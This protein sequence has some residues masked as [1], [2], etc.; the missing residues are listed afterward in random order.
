MMYLKR[1]NFS[2]RIQIQK[3]KVQ[4]CNEKLEKIRIFLVAPFHIRFTQS[5]YVVKLKRLRGSAKNHSKFLKI[6]LSDFFG[7]Q[8]WNLLWLTLIFEFGRKPQFWDT[9]IQISL[10]PSQQVLKMR[11]FSRASY[12]HPSF[13]ILR[14]IIVV[15]ITSDVFI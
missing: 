4:F 11:I 12:L 2:Q 8:P 3:K 6:F 10:Q 7:R 14:C 15:L 13:P 5:I 9:L 1:T